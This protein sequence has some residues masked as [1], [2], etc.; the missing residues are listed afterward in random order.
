MKIF[1]KTLDKLKKL[2]KYEPYSG[3]TDGNIGAFE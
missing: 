2:G 3:I 1:L